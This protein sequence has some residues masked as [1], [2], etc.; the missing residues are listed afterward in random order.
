MRTFFFMIPLSILLGIS[1][2]AASNEHFRSA[3]SSQAEAV[4]VCTVSVETVRWA[5]WEGGW[6]KAEALKSWEDWKR[7]AP[8]DSSLRFPWYELAILTLVE[9][10]YAS[11]G[12]PDD[13]QQ[14]LREAMTVCLRIASRERA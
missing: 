11:P 14:W 3:G 12:A 4:H 5:R 1:A 10:A 9:D 6:T 2:F 13:M 7:T 8:P